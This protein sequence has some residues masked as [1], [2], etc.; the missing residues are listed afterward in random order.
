MINLPAALQKLWN[1]PSHSRP[2]LDCQPHSKYSWTSNQEVADS[3]LLDTLY[4][5]YR[6]FFW[7]VL[8]KN[9]RFLTFSAHNIQGCQSPTSSNIENWSG[10]DDK[11]RHNVHGTW[12]HLWKNA[13]KDVVG[14]ATF[15]L[16]GLLCTNTLTVLLILQ[17]H[18]GVCKETF[19]VNSKIGQTTQS[20][21]SYIVRK[22]ILQEMANFSGYPGDFRL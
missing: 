10:R 18:I 19:D 16:I 9:H 1:C 15:D 4:K 14:I 21:W 2:T 11:W 6:H 17:W 3:R 5:V 13:R 22:S 8:R 20:I 12:R 7:S